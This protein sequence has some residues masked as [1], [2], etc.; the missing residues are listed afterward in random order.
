MAWA[1]LMWLSRY[2]VHCSSLRDKV[3]KLGIHKFPGILN[4]CAII[5]FSRKTLLHS[6]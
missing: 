4:S 6:M 1:G 2:S 5:S 3:M